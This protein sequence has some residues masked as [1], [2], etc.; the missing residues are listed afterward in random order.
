[1]NKLVVCPT[2][3]LV[4]QWSDELY[5]QIDVAKQIGK[6]C[7]VKTYQKLYRELK[8]NKDCLKDYDIVIMDESHRIAATTFY[9]VGMSCSNAMIIA[10]TGTPKR[11]DNADLKIQGV[12]GP[13]IYTAQ[14]EELTKQKYLTPVKVN[15]VNIPKVKITPDMDYR[16]IVREALLWNKDRNKKI[17]DIAMEKSKDGMVLILFDIIAHGEILNKQLQ[18]LSSRVIFLH[19]STQKRKEKFEDIKK[20]KYDIILA[21]RIFNEGINIPKLKTLIIASGGKS[22]IRLVQ[23][24]G[25]V[26]RLNP[27][28]IVANVYDFA[29]GCRILSKH[30]RE[31]LKVYQDNGY[32]VE[33]AI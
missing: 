26:I 15:I 1:V 25:R 22:S 20:G 21:S 28:K 31:R 23:Q 17:I 32:E 30:F 18:E 24:I 5:G 7:D 3:E 13:I 4:K 11:P 33:Y 10:L 29:D 8:E 12:C 9:K 19:G 27:E 6:K 16:D 14:I 2:T